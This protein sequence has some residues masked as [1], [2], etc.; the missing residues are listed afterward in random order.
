[1]TDTPDGEAGAWRT[2]AETAVALNLSERTIRR[3]I[4]AGRV[5]ARQEDGRL[6]VWVPTPAGTVAD[7]APAGPAA[8]GLLA[9]QAGG[10]P[11][12]DGPPAGEL[13]QLLREQIERA[14]RAEQAA[15]LWQERARNLEA[16]NS[17]LQELLALPA[18]DA[19][20][21]PRQRWWPWRRR[22]G[23]VASD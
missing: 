6:L 13:V 8:G 11:A 23:E 19:E 4:D 10:E 16:E 3:R 21:K 7:S 12:S 22:K 18:H 1:M 9:D 20:P 2:L 14:S 5:T 15:T 17:R